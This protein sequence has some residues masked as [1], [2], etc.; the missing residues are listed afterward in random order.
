MKIGLDVSQTCVETTGCGWIANELASAFSDIATSDRKIILYHHFGT[1]INSDTA[2][3]FSVNNEHVVSPLKESSPVAAKHIWESIED[4]RSE[5]PG[6]PDIV[7]SNNFSAP[8]THKTPLVMTIHDLAFWDIP[9][10]TTETNR[11][12]CQ[13]GVLNALEQADAFVFPSVFSQRRFLH[14]FGE[15]VSNNTQLHTVIPWAARFE[16]TD[17]PSQ[18]S[19]NAPWLFVGSLEPRK[20]IQNILHAF[21]LYRTK[22]TQKRTLLI[23]GPTGW[24]TQKEISHI[25]SLTK[26][27]WAKHLGYVDEGTLKSLYKEAFALIWPSLYE[28]FGLPVLES[29]SQGTPVITSRN[30]SLT[31]IGGEAAVYCDPNS[32]ESI[33]NSMLNL[34]EDR[35]GYREI[36]KD[37]LI[38]SKTFSWSKSANDLLAFYEKVLSSS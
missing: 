4:G 15:I 34:E 5:L 16:P 17:A 26:R 23:A 14:Y 21:E 25:E 12:V 22:S 30:T 11:N 8:N 7:H 24:K 31:E 28:G 10:A 29:M 3:G 19:D 32:V 2:S 37:S 20:N 38:R 6:T 27:G 1:W 36:S 9:E 18:Y 13:D 35:R 33:A